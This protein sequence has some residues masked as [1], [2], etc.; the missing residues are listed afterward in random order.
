MQ[1][2]LTETRRKHVK[3]DTDSMSAANT[4]R[5]RLLDG[6]TATADELTKKLEDL[7]ARDVPILDQSHV[8]WMGL[9]HATD[10]AGTQG[11]KISR[12]GAG[13]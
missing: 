8:H 6:K 9:T 12:A 10:P 3:L 7:E 1:I 5:F 13:A 2:E 11:G 4:S